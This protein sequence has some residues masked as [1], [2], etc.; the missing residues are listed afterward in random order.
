[1]LSV[2]LIMQYQYYASLPSLPPSVF[3][4]INHTSDPGCS[5]MKKHASTRISAIL[6]KKAT[7]QRIITANGEMILFGFAVYSPTPHWQTCA[8]TR[9]SMLAR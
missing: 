6:K 3:L 5:R 4:P 2:P 8:E 9:P 1:M 7:E